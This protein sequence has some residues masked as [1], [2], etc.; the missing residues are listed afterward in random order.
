MEFLSTERAAL[1]ESALVLVRIF[2]KGT[3]IRFVYLNSRDTLVRR[4]DAAILTWRGP[5][6]MLFARTAFAVGAQAIVAAV[7]LLRASPAS[8]RDSEPWLPVYGTLIDAGCLTLLWRFTRR[9]G[10]GLFDLVGFEAGLHTQPIG[11]CNLLSLT[12]VTTEAQT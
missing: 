9:E 11:E 2:V 6:L 7:F 4:R 1:C 10:I 8:W 12:L 5:A 3:R